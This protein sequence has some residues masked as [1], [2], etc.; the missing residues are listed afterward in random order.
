MLNC[1]ITCLLK[2]PSH[3]LE[4]GSTNPKRSQS[5]WLGIPG[6]ENLGG[7][8]TFFSSSLTMRLANH[9][10]L[11]AHAWGSGWIDPSSM[12]YYNLHSDLVGPGHVW[13]SLQARFLMLLTVPWLI[14]ICN[15]ED[16]TSA[17]WSYADFGGARQC[18]W[19]CF[20]SQSSIFNDYGMISFH[21]WFKAYCIRDHLIK[22][23][24]AWYK[25]TQTYCTRH[26]GQVC[27]DP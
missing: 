22:H 5:L 26:W 19:C 1:K 20:P 25:V 12:I 16:E 17:C 4:I 23:T 13:G 2:I 18:W 7:W 27:S 24:H 14:I 3:Y 21:I 6:K 15:L 9:K 10:Q 8:H 11:W